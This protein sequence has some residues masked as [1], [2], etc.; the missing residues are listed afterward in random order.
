MSKYIYLDTNAFQFLTESDENLINFKKWLYKNKVKPI[1]SSATISELFKFKDRFENFNSIINNIKFVYLGAY[2]RISELEKECYPN[3]FNIIKIGLNKKIEEE[4]K[5]SKFDFND[6]AKSI[7]F[8]IAL[9]NQI[10]E[11]KKFVN[12]NFNQIK[13]KSK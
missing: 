4:L 8:K 1:L 9:Q 2:V 7:R 5:G 3:K 12:I 6:L 10:E 11:A 13:N